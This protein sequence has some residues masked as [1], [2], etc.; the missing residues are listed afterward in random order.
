LVLPYHQRIVESVDVPVIWHCDGNVK[1]L[2]PMAVE[3]GFVGVQGLEP[4]AGM[5]LANV[6]REFGQDL[7][8]VG[9][10]DINVLHG[11][12]LA[13]V[14]REVDRCLAEGA[15]GSGYMLSSSN[16]IHHGLNP[17]AV[18]EYFR[19]AEERSLRT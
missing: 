18:I 4:A 15:P 12:D 3:A 13:A 14:R 16:S 10:L 7:V 5:D 1:A 19:Y 9:N 17:Q 11:A 6:K 2:L 8:L